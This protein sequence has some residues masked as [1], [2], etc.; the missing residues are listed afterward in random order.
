MYRMVIRISQSLFDGETAVDMST[1]TSP[2]G[3]NPSV[4]ISSL[5]DTI[6]NGGV[7]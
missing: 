5:I 1:G 3:T 7:A 2:P 6:S 4:F